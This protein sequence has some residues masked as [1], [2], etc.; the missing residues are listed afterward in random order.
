MLKGGKFKN[1][2]IL[3]VLMNAP[4]KTA[5]ELSP[6]R[7]ELS[8]G[9]TI[10]KNS[11][12]LGQRSEV[13]DFTFE[14]VSIST[15]EESAFSWDL[16]SDGSDKDNKVTASMSP[17]RQR[18]ITSGA[19]QHRSGSSFKTVSISKA[20]DV[21]DK[22]SI[23]DDRVDKP[24]SPSHTD[25]SNTTLETMVS[26]FENLFCCGLDTTDDPK[27]ERQKEMDDNFLGKIITCNVIVCNCEGC[28]GC[29]GR[30]P[31][32]ED[33]PDGDDVAQYR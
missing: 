6:R 13:S 11:L 8:P 25:P 12:S 26:F 2:R 10:W 24:P 27:Q 15:T 31:D 20:T 7:Y 19:S 1:A 4:K 3:K 9:G 22:M 5:V 16:S 29:G 21:T 14:P 28:T 17:S 18:Y 32:S 30:C 23:D 33:Q